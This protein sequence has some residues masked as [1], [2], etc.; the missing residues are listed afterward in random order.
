VVGSDGAVLVV[1]LVVLPV[2]LSVIKW[3]KQA[4]QIDEAIPGAEAKE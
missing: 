2:E 4:R 1:L 3:T